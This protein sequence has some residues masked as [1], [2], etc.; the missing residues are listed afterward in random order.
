MLIPSLTQSL[1]F[2]I[3]QIFFHFTN[4]YSVSSTV[5]FV[6]YGKVKSFH[7]TTCLY[8]IVTIIVM[9]V[10]TEQYIVIYMHTTRQKLQ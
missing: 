4:S 9:M 1:S 2:I 10:S 7:L 3:I 8:I 6:N 5:T